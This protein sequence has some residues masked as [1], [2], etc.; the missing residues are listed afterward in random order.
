MSNLRERHCENMKKT[1]FDNLSA[2]APLLHDDHAKPVTRREFI[3][4]GFTAGVEVP[5]EGGAVLGVIEDGGRV[6]AEHGE[7]IGITGGRGIE[8]IRGTADGEAVDRRDDRDVE[9]FEAAEDRAGQAH[10]FTKLFLGLELRI[11]FHVAAGAKKAFSLSCDDY[12]PEALVAFDLIEHI[13]K[14]VADIAAQRVS[15]FGPVNGKDQRVAKPL[16]F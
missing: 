12:G 13:E 1:K 11:A 6:D 4:Q 3:S 16:L 2:D 5:V 9:S 14:G 8:S 10:D 15:R 7:Q